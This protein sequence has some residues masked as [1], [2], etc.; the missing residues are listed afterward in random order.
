M[1]WCAHLC[2]AD[3]KITGSPFWR[4]FDDRGGNLAVWLKGCGLYDRTSTESRECGDSSVFALRSRPALLLTTPVNWLGPR[5]SDR[6]KWP[7]S[8]SEG[9]LDGVAR[10]RE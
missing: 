2:K 5:R 4:V 6:E 3:Q 10:H 7:P 8:V 9:G 1:V